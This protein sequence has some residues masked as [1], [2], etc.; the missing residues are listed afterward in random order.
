MTS[1]PAPADASASRRTPDAI[2]GVVS[3]EEEWC[4][5]NPAAAA[6]E[7]HRLLSRSSVAAMTSSVLI[8]AV[9]GTIGTVQLRYRDVA[10]LFL[11][12]ARATN[13]ASEFFVR[14]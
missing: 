11:G 5:N 10:D 14:L 13:Q 6:V 12:A 3:P 8:R 2:D 1:T 7:L 4:L 9:D